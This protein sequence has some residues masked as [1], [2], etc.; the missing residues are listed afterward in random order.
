MKALGLYFKRSSEICKFLFNVV[1]TQL[2]WIF[3]MASVLLPGKLKSCLD[4]TLCCIP[5]PSELDATVFCFKY[6][7]LS[8][9]PTVHHPIPCLCTKP[10]PL[11]TIHCARPDLKSFLSTT[12]SAPSGAM[13]LLL[14]F[15]FFFPT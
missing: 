5:V 13:S 3:W 9:V 6:E 12:E 7:A 15:P 11:A 8:R 10:F 4:Q 1:N 2:G 14:P